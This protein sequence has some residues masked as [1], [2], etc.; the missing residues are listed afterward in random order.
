MN[1]TIDASVV[2]DTMGYKLFDGPELM[3]PVVDKG[4]GSKENVIQAIWIVERYVPTLDKNVSWIS[5]PSDESL[6]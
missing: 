1:W 2:H 3:T 6:L 5:I 4:S